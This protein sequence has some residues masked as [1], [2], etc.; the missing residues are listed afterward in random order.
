MQTRL[1]Y[2][3]TKKKIYFRENALEIFTFLWDTNKPW[4]PTSLSEWCQRKHTIHILL[5]RW[6]THMADRKVVHTHKPQ[7]PSHNTMY[8]GRR[9]IFV[10]FNNM[11]R[12]SLRGWFINPAQNIANPIAS[13]ANFQELRKFNQHFVKCWTLLSCRKNEP[14]NF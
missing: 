5:W 3:K 7:A 2:K 8:V 9:C 12:L 11:M 4:C 1:I 14:T 10:Y 13:T 6:H